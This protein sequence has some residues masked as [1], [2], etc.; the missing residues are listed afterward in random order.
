MEKKR[1]Y[2]LAVRKAWSSVKLFEAMPVTVDSKASGFLLVYDSLED[3]R[4]EFPDGQYFT[5]ETGG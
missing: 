1:Y 2:V 4:A 5:V 3:L